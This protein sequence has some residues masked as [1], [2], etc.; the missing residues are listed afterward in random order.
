[1]EF[2]VGDKVVIKQLWRSDIFSE[3]TEIT[4]AGNVRVKGERGLFNKE[5]Y[6]KPSGQTHTLIRRL[7]DEEYERKKYE[8][9]VMKK[10]REIAQY[11]LKLETMPPQHIT[12][13]IIELH[14]GIQE[15]NQ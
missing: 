1:M 8:S 12:N 6:L 2:K 15:T 10:S 7:D 5:G 13:S 3:V 9:E 14:K 11:L 4:A